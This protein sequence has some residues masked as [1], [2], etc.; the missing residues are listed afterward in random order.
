MCAE[1][2]QPHATRR[3]DSLE[4]Y[5]DMRSTHGK[6][7]P[8]ARGLFVPYL[9]KFAGILF[10]HLRVRAVQG[11]HNVLVPTGKEDDFSFDHELLESVSTCTQLFKAFISGK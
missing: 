10:K 1:R 3:L 11:I 9:S 2:R 5:V 4:S 7:K 8:E 6:P